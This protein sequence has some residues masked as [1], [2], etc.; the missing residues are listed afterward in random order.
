MPFAKYNEQQWPIEEGADPEEVR[1][2]LE[3]FYPEL[4]NADYVVDDETKDIT[5]SVAAG[6]KG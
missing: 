6:T 2:S 4:A 3:I 1:S 5:F